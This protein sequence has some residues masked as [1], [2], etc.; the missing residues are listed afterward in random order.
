MSETIEPEKEAKPKGGKKKIVILIVIVV[1][2][3]A[4]GGGAFYIKSAGAKPESEGEGAQT[5]QGENAGEAGNDAAAEGEG[6]GDQDGNKDAG[7]AEFAPP[8]DENVKQIIE[9]QPFIV[10]LA[11]T[12]EARYLRLTVSIGTGEA[13]GEAKADPLFTT[14]IRNAMLSVLT[15]KSSQEV[16]TSE[17]KNML[18]KELLRAARAAAKEPKV[19][20]IY[21]TDFIVQL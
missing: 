1:L 16:L 19:E 3:L 17:G 8:D 14:R 15:T 21:I 11:D 7:A 4:G 13:E 5:A 18:R 9:L 20:A 10:N 6:K 2:A 12:T